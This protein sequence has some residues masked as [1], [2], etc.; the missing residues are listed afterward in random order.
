LDDQEADMATNRRRTPRQAKSRIPASITK[1]YLEE[2]RADDFLIECAG[3]VYRDALSSDEAKL[4]SE[5]AECGRD[6]EKWK[7]MKGV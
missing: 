1:D 2:L 4:L 6:F 5:Y 3:P 7:K